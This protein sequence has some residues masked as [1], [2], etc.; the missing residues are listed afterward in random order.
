M[1]IAKHET[2][3]TPFDFIED[4][5]SKQGS[6]TNMLHGLQQELDRIKGK[7]QNESYAVNLT[8]IHYTGN[9]YSCIISYLRYIMTAL[10]TALNSLVALN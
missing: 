4:L 8:Q 9:E 1:N 2:N 5:N 3:K 6:I 10:H 7:M